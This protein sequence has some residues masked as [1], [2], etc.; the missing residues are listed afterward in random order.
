MPVITVVIANEP[1]SYREAFGVALRLLRPRIA[2]VVVDPPKLPTS[3][4]AHRPHIVVCSHL[5]G[6]VEPGIPAWVVVDP[7]GAPGAVFDVRGHRTSVD[8]LTLDQLLE[9]IDEGVGAADC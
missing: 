4:E 5:P 9:V 6:I 7:D 1:R 2:V 8:E 3:I